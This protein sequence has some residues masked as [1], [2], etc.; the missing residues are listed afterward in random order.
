MFMNPTPRASFLR[1]VREAVLAVNKPGEAAPIPPRGA[2]GYQGAGADPLLHLQ[3]AFAAAGGV[4]H[5]VTDDASAVAKISELLRLKTPRSALVGRGKVLERLQLPDLLRGLE[6]ESVDAASAS[7]EAVFAADVGISGVDYVIAET[8]SL[9][10]LA[11]TDEP[12]SLSLLP[13]VHIAV[14]ERAQVVPDLFDL[15]TAWRVEQEDGPPVMPSCVS[16]ITGP[17]KT[18][19]I[20]LKLVT[21]VHGPGELHLVLITG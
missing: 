11:R 15:F 6:I 13:P 20:E 19:D 12:R 5:V 14:A 9:A 21:G 7:R 8:G 4:M 1:R 18:G 2:V 17:S 3:E 16:L 10:V